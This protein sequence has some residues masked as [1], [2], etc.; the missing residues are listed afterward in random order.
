[1]YNR[2]LDE[3]DRFRDEMGDITDNVSLATALETAWE[4]LPGKAG[5]PLLDGAAAAPQASYQSMTKPSGNVGCARWMCAERPCETS[6]AVS[7]CR[8]SN[9]CWTGTCP[10]WMLPN[11]RV[12]SAGR[13]MSLLYLYVVVRP[14][15]ERQL[16]DWHTANLGFVERDSAECTPPIICMSACC[17]AA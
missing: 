10:T 4:E 1:M 6:T 7:T 16:L 12:Q 9:S 5:E 2:L 8:R 17:R 13:R 14:A 15:K 11:A 3:S